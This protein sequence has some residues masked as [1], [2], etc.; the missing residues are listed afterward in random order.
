V[1]DVAGLEGVN[2]G[3][4]D[5]RRNAVGHGADLNE[6]KETGDMTG[7]RSSYQLATTPEKITS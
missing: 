1:D 3:R 7:V 6:Q 4:G 2:Q 5:G